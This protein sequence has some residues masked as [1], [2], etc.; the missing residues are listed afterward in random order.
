MNRETVIPSRH[1]PEELAERS[2]KMICESGAFDDLPY[3]V[4]TNAR[5]QIVMSPTTLYHGGLQSW[6]VRLL[7]ESLDGGMTVTEPVIQ[8]SDGNKIADAAWFSPERWDVMKGEFAASLA[9][10]VTVEVL[11]PSNSAP[12]IDHKRAL[13]LEAGAVEVWVCDL[14]GNLSFYN[15]DGELDASLLVPDAPRHIEL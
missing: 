9:P 5:G 11:S 4:E 6:I 15:E 13:Y 10:N 2:W 1:S 8:T 14:E 3:K 7:A 12:E